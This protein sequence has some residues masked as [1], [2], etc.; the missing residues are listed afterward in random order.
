LAQKVRFHLG[1]FDQFLVQ[2]SLKEGKGKEYL[3]IMGL[4]S[5][6]SVCLDSITFMLSAPKLSFL[7]GK[8][9]IFY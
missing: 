4:W 9:I 7:S 1:F 3:H 8:V 6:I 5:K 2:K